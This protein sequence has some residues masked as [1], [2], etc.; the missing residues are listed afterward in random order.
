M[1]NLLPLWAQVLV[2]LSGVLG[3]IG[4]LVAI[5]RQRERDKWEGE[6][7]GVRVGADAT[8]T[9]TDSAVKLIDELQERVDKLHER[10]EK[11]EEQRDKLACRVKKLEQ[12]KHALSAEVCM[13]REVVRVRDGRIDELEC[14]N[15]S[16]QD[17]VARLEARV[18]ELEARNGGCYGKPIND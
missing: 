16:L 17:E 6:Q 2:A 12:D 3:G 1:E 7:A 9:L 10:T 18:K 14:E 15:K 11:L 4:G 5:W 8:A 13:L